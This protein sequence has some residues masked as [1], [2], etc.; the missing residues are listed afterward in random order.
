MKK[1]FAS[2][3]FVFFGCFLLSANIHVPIPGETVVK[4]DNIYIEYLSIADAYFELGKYDKACDYYLLAMK[5]KK[6]YWTAFYKL[7][8]TYV[9]LKNWEE[10]EKIF[11]KLLK[12]DSENLSLKMS[13]AYIT[14]MNGK[15]D[16]AKE[17]YK[18]LWEENS[19]NADVLV[20][21]INV[22]IAQEDYDFAKTL[23]GELK[24]KFNDNKNISVF[25]KKIEEIEK[26]TEEKIENQDSEEVENKEL[27]VS[28]DDEKSSN[29][30]N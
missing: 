11:A 21:Y 15:L 7:G 3:F 2:V 8:R 22:V 26:Q 27:E 9:L 19:E 16:S 30:K 23:I 29:S 10:A 20:N 13:L 14:A 4:K 6:L 28:S 18:I 12:R 1:V 25:E 17:M 5:N 24:E